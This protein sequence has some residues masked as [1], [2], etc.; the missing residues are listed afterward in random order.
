LVPIRY[1]L[2]TATLNKLTIDASLS[3]P[4]LIVSQAPGAVGDLLALKSGAN[5]LGSI[6]NTGFATLPGLA[7]MSNSTNLLIQPSSQEYAV[8]T[9]IIDVKRKDNTQLMW[10]DAEGDVYIKGDLTVEGTTQYSDTQHIAGDLTVDGNIIL[11]DSIGAYV[12]K[13]VNASDQVV[14]LEVSSNIVLTSPTQTIDSI[15]IATHNHSG[16]AGKG[17]QISYTNLTNKPSSG[18]WN[19]DQTVNGT[20]LWTT[21]TNTATPYHITQNQGKIWQDHIESAHAP[22]DA[23]DNAA[24]V[25]HTG[26]T[27]AHITATERT[28][29]N[30]AKTHADSTHAPSDA[31]S[32]SVFIGHTGNVDAHHNKQHALVGTDHTASG[33][34]AGHFLKATGASTFGFA[35]HGLTYTDVGAA[36]SSHTS[37]IAT[38]STLGH[39][40]VGTG[41]S[42]ASGIVSVAY[43]TTSATACVG[44][45]ARLSNARTP[46]AHGN[47][48]HSVAYI[49][50]ADG[51]ARYLQLTGG[52]LSGDI[53]ISKAAPVLKLLP[54]ATNQAESGEIFFGDYP[55]ETYGMAIKYNGSTNAINIV[56]RSSGTDTTR[57]TIARDTGNITAGAY[58]G[59]TINT[60]KGGRWDTA[61]THSQASHAPSDAPSGATFS[62]HT[63]DSGVHVTSAKQTQWSTAYTHSQAAHAPSDA[64][65]NATFTGHT[66][67]TTVHITSAERT[68]WNAAKTHADSTHA[69]SD[70]PSNSTFTGHTGNT[71]VH[72][73][74]AERTNWNSAKTHADSAHAYLPLAGGT[75]TGN[76]SIGSGVGII[77]LVPDDSTG[78]WARGW[79]IKRA[80]NNA[81]E[82]SI[83]LRG[84]LS[85]VWYGY[86]G[87]AHDVTFIRFYPDKRITTDSHIDIGGELRMAGT[88]KDANWDTAYTHSQAAHAPSDSP[89]GSTFTN[90][91]GNANAHHSQA[92]DIAGSDHTGTLSIAK[93]G[94]GASSMADMPTEATAVMYNGTKMGTRELGSMA[95]ASTSSYDKYNNWNLWVGGTKQLTVGSNA[96]VKFVAGSNVN[97]T[98]ASNTVTIGMTPPA[99]KYLSSVSGTCGGTVTFT[100]NDASTTTW[101]SAHTHSYLPLSGGT[102]N[103]NL[104]VGVAAESYRLN[105]SGASKFAGDITLAQAANVTLGSDTTSGVNSGARQYTS[106]DGSSVWFN[107]RATGGMA[108]R[109]DALATPTIEPELRVYEKGFAPAK[110]LGITSSG[111][112]TTGS[113][114]TFSIGGSNVFSIDSSGAITAGTIP[115]SSVTSPPWLTTAT[116][117]SAS[118]SAKGIVQLSTSTSSTSTTLAATASAVKAAYDKGNHSH[119]YL[120]TAGGT[121]TGALNIGSYAILYNATEQSLDFVFN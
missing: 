118:T 41:L 106:V 44:N 34:T 48:R 89:S 30:A 81:T 51:D 7:L 98:Y 109:G 20:R 23:P 101:N 79:Q 33:L 5:T 95:F 104:G 97:L 16:A 83:G 40:K 52:T 55:D 49:A 76:L 99:D 4:A 77:S 110:Y 39:I 74:A 11:K 100:M 111:I 59:V 42:I 84:H 88:R 114:L 8:D 54:T 92:H 107:F 121:M 86:I 36:P 73:T 62:G 37:A 108:L 45:D 38:D 46:I 6:A 87:K 28:N 82:M 18:S 27:T 103:G 94:T 21:G 105:V 119:P 93:G 80:T 15:Q 102:V 68:A 65:S 47:E 2:D 22:S 63:S 35:A 90:H 17:V 115:A 25:S 13:A 14:D 10:L 9:K 26:N 53:I 69:P 85:E 29:W 96:D 57:V 3:S 112:S 61:Y 56:G 78:G 58:N 72:I 12:L 70:A 120:P 24:F 113:L 116:L 19:H 67:N 60:T 71:T 43:G 91:T 32:S 31:P 50:Q 1:P 66:G 64:P 75:M 117:P